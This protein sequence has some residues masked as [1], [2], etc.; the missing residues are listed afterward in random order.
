M[1]IL[2][3]IHRD[4]FPE[5]VVSLILRASFLQS[6]LHKHTTFSNLGFLTCCCR[7]GYVSHCTTQHSRAVLLVPSLTQRGSAFPSMERWPWTR[8]GQRRPCLQLPSAQ[9]PYPCNGS[10]PK[11]AQEPQHQNEMRQQSGKTKTTRGTMWM[12][13]FSLKH[14]DVAA[15]PFSTP[16]SVKPQSDSY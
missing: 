15:T 10:T 16:S 2:Q 11:P 8:L 1:P 6:H 14:A 7:S 4:V 5:R 3:C 9:L 13:A 12:L